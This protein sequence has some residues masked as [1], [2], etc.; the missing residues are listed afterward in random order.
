M[1]ETSRVPARRLE[2]L[3]ETTTSRQQRA[4]TR[5]E[6]AIR[7]YND[8]DRV[9]DLLRAAL[10]DLGDEGFF[11]AIVHANLAWVAICRL[12]PARAVDHARAAIGFAE[13]I[14]DPR[15]LRVA[16]DVLGEAR[17]AARAGDGADDAPGGGDRRRPRSRRDGAAREDPRQVSCSGREDRGGL[18][19][20]RQADRHLVEAGLELMRH[21]TLPLLSEVECAA[22][23]WAAAA[24]HA[25]EGYDIV[26]DAGLEELRD[27]MLYARARVAA[28]VGRIDDA[29]RDATEGLSLATA[30]GIVGRGRAPERAGVRRAVDG[31]SRRGR[32]R[33]RSRRAAPGRE[34]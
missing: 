30:R 19:S 24:R 2:T 11:T 1:R 26:V 18:A 12:E 23:D 9:D 15:A 17:V 21:D 10:P 13:R 14:A 29:R 25:D 20:V 28:L 8:V 27:Q 31:R 34:R 16:L 5:M 33:A 7:S 6:L 32:P 4:M 22:G 3:I